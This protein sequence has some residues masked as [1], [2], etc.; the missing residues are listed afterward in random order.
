MYENCAFR[1]NGIRKN[2]RK[3]RFSKERHSKEKN[4]FWKNVI[5]SIDLV[6]I[7]LTLIPFLW[8]LRNSSLIYNFYL[9]GHNREMLFHKTLQYLNIFELKGIEWKFLKMLFKVTFGFL[10][11][12]SY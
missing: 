8:Y 9:N 7:K 10:R 12:C 3:L 6:P 4:E 11:L 1:K 2:V 5:R